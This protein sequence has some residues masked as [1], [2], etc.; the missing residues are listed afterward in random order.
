MKKFHYALAPWWMWGMLC[1]VV[2]GC[3]DGN[4]NSKMQHG[5]LSQR[6]LES[7][8]G[9]PSSNYQT[10]EKQKIH[11]YPNE[12]FQLDGEQVTYYYRQ[13]SEEEESLAYWM[14]RW[15]SD[16]Y[17]LTTI[18]ASNTNDLPPNLHYVNYDNNERF[19]YHQATQQVTQ[20]IFQLTTKS[21]KNETD[22]N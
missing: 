5:P 2:S 18:E 12:S 13:P 19:I 7:E 1:S 11:Q 6:E 22:S 10:P 3:G 9:E 4:F 15:S 21:Q 16:I 20:V 8:K 17:H 14:E